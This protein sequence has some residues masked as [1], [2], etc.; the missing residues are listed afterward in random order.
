[1]IIYI[2]NKPYEQRLADSN[3][4]QLGMGQEMSSSDTHLKSGDMLPVLKNIKE[5]ASKATLLKLSFLCI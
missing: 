1:M 5:T 2:Y 3:G 4:Q